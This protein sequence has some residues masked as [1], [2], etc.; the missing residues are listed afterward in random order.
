MV[1]ADVKNV[2]RMIKMS[3]YRLIDLSVCIENNSLSESRS[4]IIQYIS[5]EQGAGQMKRI[6]GAEPSEFPSKG[7][8]WAVEIVTASTHAGTHVD[9]PYHYG[10]ESE[11]KPAKTIDE[12]PLEWFYGDGVI[13][14]FRHKKPGELITVKDLKEAL[15]EIGYIIKPGDIVLLMTGAD[16]HW[17]S[18]KYLNVHPGLSREAVLWL[19]KKGVKVIGTDAWGLD[20]AFSAIAKE[21][22]ETKNGKIIWEAHFAGIEKEYCQIE[23]LANLDKIPKPYGFKVAA[24]PVKIKGASGGWTRAVAII[25]GEE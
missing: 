18:S 23:K 8:G 13:L 16:K 12:V 17:G 7:T 15:K 3:R 11:G 14:D 20:R 10:K 5:H 6:F 25:E 2:W 19:V 1:L 22:K 4:P 9:A 24:F 21:Y